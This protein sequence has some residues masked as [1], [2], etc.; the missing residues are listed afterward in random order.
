[1]PEMEASSSSSE[2]EKQLESQVE[3]HDSRASVRSR[4]ES[5]QELPDPDA[6]KSPEERQKIVC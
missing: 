2:D 1:M 5:L 6:E 3:R 4:S